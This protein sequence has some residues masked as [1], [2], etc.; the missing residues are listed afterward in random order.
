MSK[1][2]TKF[3]GEIFEQELPTGDV[4][5]V[6]D[7]FTLSSVPHSNKSVIV[8]LNGRALIQGSHYTISGSTI[9]F[10]GAPELGQIVHCFY[11]K[12]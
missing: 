6:N 9:T 5:G 1:L 10:A 2:K 4:D 7:E 8:F 12:R 3:I 11:I